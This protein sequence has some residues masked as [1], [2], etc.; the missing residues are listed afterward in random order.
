M[1]GTKNV[2][3]SG[4]SKLNHRYFKDCASQQF[5]ATNLVAYGTILTERDLSVQNQIRV[6][7]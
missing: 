5:V 1:L 7:Q 6:S 3:Y 2:R 4:I